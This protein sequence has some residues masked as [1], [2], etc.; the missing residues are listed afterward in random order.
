MKVFKAFSIIV[1]AV[2]LAQIYYPLV[3]A[4]IFNRVVAQVNNEVVT[5]YEL[6]MKIKEL[7]GF[8]PGDL[9][10]KD[11]KRF[12]EIRRKIID[13][14]V[15]EKITNEKIQELGIQVT[16]NEIDAAIERIK[17]SNHLTHEDLLASLTKQQMSYES[18]RERIKRDLERTRLINFEVKSKIIIREE[19]IKEYYS[20][21]KD[22]FSTPENVHLAAIF[23]KQKDP[24]NQ[25]ETLA[26]Y[27]KAEEIVA[28]LKRGENFTDMAR[29]LSQGPGAEEGGDLGL[30]KTSQLDPDLIKVVKNMSSGDISRPIMRPAGIQIVKLVE[31]QDGGVEP[32]E[33]VRDAIFGILYQEE[34]NKRYFSWIK[35]LRKKAYTK[36][37]F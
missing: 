37:I 26:L 10:M 2:I 29:K 13:F 20:K 30:F 32:F 24:S 18:Y 19:E 5:L 7:T 36:I 21:N 6:N 17:Q 31:K 9:R 35:E 16:P 25:E 15:D 34:I 3:S 11:E 27:R 12:L 22:K 28:R 14:L 1:G 8:D 4:E 33:T 23:L